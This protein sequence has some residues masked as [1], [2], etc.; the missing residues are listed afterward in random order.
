M[1][2]NNNCCQQFRRVFLILILTF[3]VMISAFSQGLKFYGTE[4]S[5]AGRTG[6]T[7]FE[8]HSPKFRNMLEM[9]FRM[10]TYPSAEK[11]YVFRIFDEGDPEAC[12]VN[13]HYDGALD[14]HRFK[15]NLEN[16][17][18]LVNIDFRKDEDLYTARWMDVMLLLDFE[19]DSVTLKID[20]HTAKAYL[21]FKNRSIRPGITFGK[22]G[23]QIDVP[24]FAIKDLTISD[25]SSKYVFALDEEQ[26]EDVHEYAN[27]RKTGKVENPIWLAQNYFNWRIQDIVNSSTFLC[28]GYDENSHEVWAYN[29]DSIRFFNLKTRQVRTVRFN[30]TC[31]LEISTGQNFYD[32]ST[33][34][35]YAYEP[36]IENSDS[37][38]VSWAVLDTKTWRWTALSNDILDMPIYHHGE[39][40]DTANNRF[41]VYGGFGNEKFNGEIYSFSLDG[42]KWNKAGDIVSEKPWPRYFCAAGYSA[43]DSSLYVYGGMG[44][45]SGYQVVG[46]S[47]LYDLYRINTKTLVSEKLWSINWDKDSLDCVPARNMILDGNGSFYVLCYPEYLT[48]S[49]LQLYKFSIKDG[50]KSAIGSRIKIMSD[51][52]NTNAVLYYD[53]LLKK[54]ITI[55]EETPDDHSSIVSTYTIEFPPALKTDKYSILERNRLIERAVT[56]GII[57]I[58]L[59]VAGIV[60]LTIRRRRRRQRLSLGLGGTTYRKTRIKMLPESPNQIRLFGNLL[61]MDRDG[62]DISAMFTEKIKQ[63]FMLILQYCDKGGI[64]SKKLSSLTWPDKDEEKAKNIRG[65]TLNN[66][67]KILNR[68]DGIALVFNEGKYIIQCDA[69]AVCDWFE[70]KTEL[71]RPESGN[72][73]L[74]SILSR[75]KFLNGE[76]DPFYDNIK[77][78]ME[79]AVTAKMLEEAEYRFGNEDYVNLLLCTEIIFRIDPLNE[80][81][82]NVTIKSLVNMGQDEEAKVR[83]NQFISRYKK[84]MD[85]DYPIS[86]EKIVSA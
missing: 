79:N 61:V 77:E 66:L 75:G 45:E 1:I 80:F 68:M 57:I 25:K 36:Y 55:T 43:Q 86:Y 38:R 33:G 70:A 54:L 72:D 56:I 41:L 12:P 64:S 58:V 34:K 73:R 13:L 3:S 23:Y 22:N 2:L 24:S 51:K 16:I 59:V 74:L 30:N 11:G 26:G 44:N 9:E 7:V 84:D 5:I 48:K 15:L 67:R 8:K 42:H 29:R 19:R 83:Y 69:P 82:L 28:K 65:V 78:D 4:C 14:Y 49:N 47:Y 27:G 85:E 37:T 62:E 63:V 53:S 60:G 39:W 6:Y 71:L 50:E 32:S 31:P 40:L 35:Y 76:T 52:I 21:P 46:R 17:K 81:A 10:L 20:D 18:I